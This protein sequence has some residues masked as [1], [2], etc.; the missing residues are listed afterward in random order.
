MTGNI[1]D[2]SM[3][4]YWRPIITA[5]WRK[6]IDGIMGAAREL[7]KAREALKDQR[8]EWGKLTGE[9]TGEPLLPFGPSTA[10]RLMK[11][12]ENPVLSNPAHGQDLPASWRTLYELTKVPDDELEQALPR[13]ARNLLSCSELYDE[14]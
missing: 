13:R 8:G 11:V 2:E 4:E 9:T 14:R 7:I 12:G 6:T 1:V 5:E 10:Q 3:A